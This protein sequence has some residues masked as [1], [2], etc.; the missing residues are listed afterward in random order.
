MGTT[1]SKINLAALK[2][3]LM[4]QE[5]QNGKVLGV[6]IPI[7]ANHL[8]HSA[9]KGNVYLDMISFDLKEPKDN[10]THLTKQSLPKD[11]RDAMTKEQQNE[12]PI[13]GSLNTAFG[14]GGAEV[15]NNAAPGVVV[16]EGD[17]LPF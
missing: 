2:H 11:V 12:M 3:V 13:I 10:Q 17:K 7:K 6:F 1:T 8:F 14:G 4:E 15:S 5:G 16:K 9:E